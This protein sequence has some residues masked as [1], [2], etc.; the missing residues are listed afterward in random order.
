MWNWHSAEEIE[1]SAVAYELYQEVNGGYARRLFGMAF[2]LASFTF[3]YSVQT[4]INLWRT[5]SLFKAKTFFG[6]ISF[7]FGRQ[8]MFWI[9][10]GMLFSYLSPNWKPSQDAFQVAN[11][12]I[13][14]H[15][16]EFKVLK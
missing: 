5:R 12:W 2:A 13:E 14:A 11:D 6:A 16:T 3:D 7:L 10:T 8:G 1:H 4:T 15:H 9:M